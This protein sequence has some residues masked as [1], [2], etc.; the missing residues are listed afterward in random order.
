MCTAVKRGATAAE[1][2][3]GSGFG[4]WKICEI[5][6]DPLTSASVR[7]WQNLGP[8]PSAYVLVLGECGAVLVFSLLCMYWFWDKVA[9]CWSLPS[10]CELV[11]GESGEVMVPSFCVYWFWENGGNLTISPLCWYLQSG[12]ILTTM[13]VTK[14]SGGVA[15]LKG[16]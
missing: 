9:Q 15:Q 13:D 2:N 4:F 14:R 6:P 11:L 10:V 1:R 8:L 5:S 16:C 7:E 12:E 3:Q